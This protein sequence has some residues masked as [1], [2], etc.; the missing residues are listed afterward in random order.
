VDQQQRLAASLKKLEVVLVER[1]ADADEVLHAP[2]FNPHFQTHAGAKRETTQSDIQLRVVGGKVIESGAHVVALTAS[3]VMFACTLA[4][5]AKVDSQSGQ[6][7]VV[8]G[9]G[10]T[11]NDLVVHRAAAQRMRME[12]KGHTFSW[13]GSRFL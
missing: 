13:P 11:K 7:G 6:A 12:N 4:D 1:R 3:F 5:A 8:Q 10:G 2:V 9:R